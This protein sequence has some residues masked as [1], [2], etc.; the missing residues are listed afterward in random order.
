MASQ[1]MQAVANHDPS[2]LKLKT[3][4]TDLARPAVTSSGTS[5]SQRSMQPGGVL[6]R[7]QGLFPPSLS[8]SQSIPT[9][10]VSPNAVTSPLV[11][12]PEFIKIRII[13]WNMHDSLPKVRLMTLSCNSVLAEAW[14]KGKLGRT[15]GLCTIVHPKVD[16]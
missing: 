6:A 12:N 1:S 15:F 10:T 8:S 5:R 2:L 11:S 16:C 3:S 7:L 14:T 13:T 9:P 4:R